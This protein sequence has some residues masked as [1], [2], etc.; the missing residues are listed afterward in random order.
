MPDSIGFHQDAKILVKGMKDYGFGIWRLTPTG[1]G[2]ACYDEMVA[3]TAL[4]YYFTFPHPIFMLIFNALLQSIVVFVFFK[5]LIKITK[6]KKI[7][8]LSSSIFLIFPSQFLFISQIQRD[9]IFS[10]GIIV[11]LYLIVNF[12]DQLNKNKINYILEY[13]KIIILTLLILLS[14]STSRHYY[15]QILIMFVCF[16]FI[17]QTLYYIFYFNKKFNIYIFLQPV[18]VLVSIFFFSFFLEFNYM[19]QHSYLYYLFQKTLNINLYSVEDKADLVYLEIKETEIKRAEVVSKTNS[20]NKDVVVSEPSNLKTKFEHTIT[21]TD[22]EKYNILEGNKSFKEIRYTNWIK[23]DWIPSIID[24]KIKGLA[25]SRLGFLSVTG[26]TNIDNDVV[27]KNSLDV[28]NYM[29]RALQIGLYSPFPKFIFNNKDY[30]F[31]KKLLTIVFLESIFAIIITVLFLFYFKKIYFKIENFILINFCLSNIII[32]CL[33]V[34]NIGTIVRMRYI[35]FSFILCLI[36]SNL[37]VL[38]KKFKN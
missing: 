1:C 7:S 5:I 14:I 16:I 13:I 12:F 29:P 11:Y 4:I 31:S 3:V 37:L 22:Y 33:A 17:I 36:I 6:N 18:L 38:N 21:I 2:T 27:F 35:F 10:L 19:K 28:F 24:N 26:N 20:V 8:F 15:I 25:F 32:F 34:N 23:F 9:G 30:N